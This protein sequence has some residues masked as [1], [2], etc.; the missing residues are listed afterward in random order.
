MRARLAAVE[1]AAAAVAGR[2]RPRMLVLE[3]TDPPYLAGHWL[4]ELVRRAG[5]TRS[6]RSRAAAASPW[7]GRTS[8]G[9]CRPGRACGLGLDE[10]LE[11]SAGVAAHLPGVPLVAI[12]SARYVVQAGP[13]LVDGVEALAWVLHP[14]AVPEP[15]HGRV[16]RAPAST[17]TDPRKAHA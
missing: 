5:A 17:P 12:D 9:R 2:S 11:L 13:A 6:V 7:R 15:P 16:A 14:D 8:R 1:V 10:A 3:W 4:P